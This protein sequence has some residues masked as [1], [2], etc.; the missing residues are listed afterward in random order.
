MATNPG[1]CTLHHAPGA[2]S[3]VPLV[4][5]EA[6]GRPYDVVTVKLQQ[7]E[8]HQAVFQQLNPKGKVPVL[9]HNHQPLTENVAIALW[10]AQQH[11]AARLLPAP[12]DAWAHAQAVSWL[13]WCATTLHPLI[14]RVRMAQRVTDLAEAQPG[15]KRLALEELGKQLL[16]AERHLQHHDWLDQGGR[17][18]PDIY[19]YWCTGRAL[20]AGLPADTVPHLVAHRERVHAL[21]EVQR[22]LERESATH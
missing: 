12:G 17:T 13:A 19:L 18:A 8:Q 5:L 1:T 20:E 9:V 15:V 10:L 2:C 14:F 4:L 22:A 7:G 6:T 3:R 16:V 11:P 21:P